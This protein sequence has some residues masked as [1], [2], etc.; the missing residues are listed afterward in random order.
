MS[1]KSDYY[2]NLANTMIKKFAG[3]NIDAV[4]CPDSAA[5]AQKIRDLIPDGAS[6][7][8]GGS[9]TLNE[10]GIMDALRNGNYEVIDRD[11]A[12]SPEERRAMFARQAMADYFLMSTNAFTADGELVNIDGRGNRVALMISGPEHVIIVT[13]MNKFARDIDSAIKRVQNIASP[14]NCVRL[15]RNTP[16]AKTGMCGNC[17]SDET[18]CCQ[19]VVTRHSMIKGRIT[20]VMVGEDLGY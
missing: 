15:S 20:V 2:A 14:P 8:W 6:V 19:I 11:T 9:M 10:A 18:I 1:V 3:R 4:Y 12:C 16:C 13:G 7:T 17:H 5:A